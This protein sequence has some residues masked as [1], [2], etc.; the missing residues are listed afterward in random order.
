MR[1]WSRFLWRKSHTGKY[2]RTSRYAFWGFWQTMFNSSLKEKKEL[3]KNDKIL[4]SQREKKSFFF[5][6]KTAG[7]LNRSFKKGYAF[8]VHF[9]NTV[10]DKWHWNIVWK[11][12]I[13]KIQCLT[14]WLFKILLS[15]TMF[16]A[17]PSCL[18]TLT[19]IFNWNIC[20]GR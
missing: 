11:I 1:E 17:F 8:L 6:D 3:Q 19:S 13:L 12:N 7:F 18:S 20:L 9:Y 2:F 4:D 15:L 14:I 5:I 16:W 10:I